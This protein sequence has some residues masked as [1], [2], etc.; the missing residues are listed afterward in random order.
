MNGLNR[1]VNYVADL[2]TGKGKMDGSGIKPE[3]QLPKDLV[4]GLQKCLKKYEKLRQEMMAV[5][6]ELNVLHAKI[7]AYDPQIAN[8]GV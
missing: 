8:A 3:S 1:G 7:A 4:V 5:Q 6:A 2:L